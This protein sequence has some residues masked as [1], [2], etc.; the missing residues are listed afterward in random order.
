DD[1]KGDVPLGLESNGHEPA[2][3]EESAFADPGRLRNTSGRGQTSSNFSRPHRDRQVRS[4][5]LIS[6]RIL[7]CRNQAA[8]PQRSS[9]VMSVRPIRQVIHTKS[10]I[11]GAGVKLQRAF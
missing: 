8:A 7:P 9:S 5:R 6:D 10:T 2:I 3:L 1:D 11:E 4:A